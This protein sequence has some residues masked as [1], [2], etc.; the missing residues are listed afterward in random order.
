MVIPAP[1]RVEPSDRVKRCK[2][3]RKDFRIR[4]EIVDGVERRVARWTAK[5]GGR[6]RVVATQGKREDKRLAN[7]C[8]TA[9]VNTDAGLKGW[10]F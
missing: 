1:F 7:A 2:A 3:L 9:I 10:S 8:L 4:N 6:C 5:D